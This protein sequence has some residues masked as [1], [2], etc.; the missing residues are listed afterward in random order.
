MVLP[1]QIV[2]LGSSSDSKNIQIPHPSVSVGTTFNCAEHH[3]ATPGLI[4]PNYYHPSC[5]NGN[6]WGCCRTMQGK[7]VIDSTKFGR[8][9]WST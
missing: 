2:D 9:T 3:Y 5:D 7:K 1:T 6:D 8:K 4:L